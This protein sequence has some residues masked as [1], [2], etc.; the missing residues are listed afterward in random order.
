MD[1]YGGELHERHPS[2][3]AILK[4]LKVLIVDQHAI[5]SSTISSGRR[6]VWFGQ[7]AF[8]YAAAY[9]R[10]LSSGA[11]SWWSSRRD[12]QLGHDVHSVHLEHPDTSEQVKD[13]SL[14]PHRASERKLLPGAVVEC[15]R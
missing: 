7:G 15:Y 11:W 5:I 8:V 9:S 2:D 14:R 4:P 12:L 6:A 13:G 1:I 3:L 10:Q